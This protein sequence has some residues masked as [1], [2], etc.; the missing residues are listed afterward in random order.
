MKVAVGR[1]FVFCIPLLLDSDVKAR[2][3]P[4]ELDPAVPL[5]YQHGRCD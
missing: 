2:H 5:R 3:D 1:I 4:E